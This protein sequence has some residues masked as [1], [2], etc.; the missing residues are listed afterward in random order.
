MTHWIAEG[1]HQGRYERIAPTGK[2]FKVTAVDINYIKNGKFT[3]CRT[4]MDE[5]GLL[6][7]L[8]IWNNNEPEENAELRSAWDQIAEGYNQFV[9]DTE[10][11]L[12]NE[13]LKRVGLQAGQLFWMFSWLWWFKFARCP[14]RCKSIGNGLVSGNDQAFPDACK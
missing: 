13:A 9:T 8:G 14:S 1:T 2:H 3:E 12:A 7:Q 5:L 11:W 10:T 4:N 6:Q